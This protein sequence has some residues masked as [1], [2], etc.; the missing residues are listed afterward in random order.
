MQWMT[1]SWMPEICRE[2]PAGSTEGAPPPPAAP[3]FT[4]VDP[5]TSGYL[6]N[7]GWDKLDAKDVA[8]K[9]ITAH[10]EAEKLIGVPSNRVVRLP[11][12]PADS[13]AMADV[14]KKLGMPN[15]AKDYD[16]SNVKRAGDKPLDAPLENA[17]RAALHNGRVTKDNATAVAKEIVKHL[18]TAAGEADVARSTKLNEEKETLA[19]SWGTNAV[20]NQLI[21]Q[22]AAKALGVEPEAVAALEG[23]VGYSKVMEMFRLI[24]T[25]IG[26]DKFLG[27]G[28]P[29]G[30]PSI[31]T[32]EQAQARLQELKADTEW[33]KAYLNGDAVKG[34]EM[35]DLMKLIH[36]A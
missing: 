13:A 17:I 10:R 33:S 7:R 2:A 32:R 15:E 30:G 18:D 1:R 29:H 5:E 12:N 26:E 22:N 21:A 6:T 28:N 34:R 8:L 19:K 31:A 11:E 3:W 27:G 25:K 16:L 36:G 9:A 23:V 20:A 14:F 4:G 24:G 35:A